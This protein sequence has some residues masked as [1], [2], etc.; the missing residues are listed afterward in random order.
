MVVENSTFVCFE[1]ILVKP[2]GAWCDDYFFISGCPHV[3]RRFGGSVVFFFQGWHIDFW[4]KLVKKGR[5]K[6]RKVGKG[7][8]PRWLLEKEDGGY[9]KGGSHGL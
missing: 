5:N 9:W 6:A 2:S 8:L 3:N 7:D 4:E 1:L